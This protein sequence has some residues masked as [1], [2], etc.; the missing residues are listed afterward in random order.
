MIQLFDKFKA[1]K[2]KE[3]TNSKYQKATK[4]KK[5]TLRIKQCMNNCKNLEEKEKKRKQT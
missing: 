3:G 1:S 5:I 4:K 2:T